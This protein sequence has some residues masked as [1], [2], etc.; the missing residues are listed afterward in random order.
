[1]SSYES[2][3]KTWNI[4]K[5]NYKKSGLVN[6][7]YLLKSVSDNYK[8]GYVSASVW[9]SKDSFIRS[10]SENVLLRYH[11]SHNGKGNNSAAVNLYRLAAKEGNKIRA[12]KNNVLFVTLFETPK[13]S[14][15]N[16][17]EIWKKLLDVCSEKNN[18]MRAVLLKAV[19]SKNKF[20]YVSLIRLKNYENLEN[21]RQSVSILKQIRNYTS[22]YNII[23]K[24]NTY[25]LIKPEKL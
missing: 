16:V 14:G 1:M 17:Y 8:F 11:H 24:L 18:L 22:S 6:E 2:F 9:N 10:L 5:K 7:A 4:I 13:E 12:D 25:K 20:G 23:E 21:S 19:Y 3:R 15:K